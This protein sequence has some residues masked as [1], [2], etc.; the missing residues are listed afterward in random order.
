MSTAYVG[1]FRVASP[2]VPSPSFYT[3][4]HAT[5][6]DHSFSSRAEVA[7]YATDV[8][9]ELKIWEKEFASTHSG[10]KAGREDIKQNPEIGTLYDVAL[11]RKIALLPIRFLLTGFTTTSCQVQ[12]I[13]PTQVSRGHSRSPRESP[14]RNRQPRQEAKT[15]LT[16]RRRDFQSRCDSAQVSQRALCN[17]V[18][19]P[20]CKNPPLEPRPV[21]FTLDVPQTI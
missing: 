10:K 21:R 18:Q 2:L 9:S 8:R 5:M 20:D 3:L 7:D 6:A 15:C 17:P 1:G 11:A 12:G 19:R 4:R 14:A 13:Q 16:N